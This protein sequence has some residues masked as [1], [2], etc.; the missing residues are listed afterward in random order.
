MKRSMRFDDPEE[1]KK[2]I[3]DMVFGEI[4]FFRG[5]IYEFDGKDLKYLPGLQ[6]FF[7]SMK[8]DYE[9][10]QNQLRNPINSG[11]WLDWRRIF[12]ELL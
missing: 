2:V 8:S 9:N 5:I 11:F 4:L 10:F 12:S 6:P 3:P 7:K 1:V